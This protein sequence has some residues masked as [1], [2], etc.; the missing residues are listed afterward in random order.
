M[1]LFLRLW[2]RG[3]IIFTI[4]AFLGVLIDSTKPI[5][6]LTGS[7]SIDWVITFLF[8]ITPFGSIFGFIVV[9][10]LLFAF[11][12]IGVLTGQGGRVRSV[13]T[14]VTGIKKTSKLEESLVNKVRS[15][16][17]KEYSP[18]FV[19]NHFNND[20]TMTGWT[21]DDGKHFDRDGNL[22]G[23]TDKKGNNYNREGHII[24]HTNKSFQHFDTNGNKIGWTD[25]Q[26]KQ[27][28]RDGNMNSYTLKK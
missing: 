4:I 13:A 11:W 6:K 19:G 8:G 20:G 5:I 21:T 3:S 7:N 10:V 2:I 23:W 28:D 9:F 16:R 22:N 18:Y 27:F 17:E 12:I 26:G 24:G 25:K 15:N 14:R 1:E